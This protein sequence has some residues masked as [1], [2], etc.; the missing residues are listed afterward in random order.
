MNTDT[1]KSNSYVIDYETRKTI[2]KK[3]MCAGVTPVILA[4][5]YMLATWGI[6]FP[7]TLHKHSKLPVFLV[8]SMFL[9]IMLLILSIVLCCVICYESKKLIS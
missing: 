4:L 3:R 8:L 1:N 9:S 5:L 2:Y 6:W 7:I